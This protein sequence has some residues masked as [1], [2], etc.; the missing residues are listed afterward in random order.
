MPRVAVSPSESAF[1]RERVARFAEEAPPELC[2]ERDHVQ[3][4][5]ALPL[6]LGWTETLAIRED[7]TLVSWTTEEWPGAR[8]FAAD[9]WINIALVHGAKR[10]PELR[11]LIPQRP[12]T[13]ATCD[14]CN[15]SGIVNG[16][17][18]GTNL[19]CKCAG[20]GWLPRA[21]AT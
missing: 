3:E 7:G 5:Q 2:W 19:L 4:H 13:A 14:G 15:G 16:L 8:E 12:G 1:I 17:P 11:G 10:Y 21:T 18:A 6:Y 20:L 9:N